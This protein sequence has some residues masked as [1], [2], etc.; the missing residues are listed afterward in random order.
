MRKVER[1]ERIRRDHAQF[2]WGIRRLA[3]EHRCHRRDVRQALESAVPPGR[4]SP[5][6]ERP[7]LGPWVETID[8]VLAADRRAPRKQRHTAHRISRRPIKPPDAVQALQG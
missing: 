2:G 5:A 1:Y 8:S 6:R 4:R 3:R 7:V